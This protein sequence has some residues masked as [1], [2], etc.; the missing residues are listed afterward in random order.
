MRGSRTDRLAPGRLS[1]LKYAGRQ[2]APGSE[3]LILEKGMI[4]HQPAGRRSLGL[5]AAQPRLH[6]FAQQA[7]AL[8]QT[9]RE[10]RPA[11]GGRARIRYCDG[12]RAHW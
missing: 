8:V 12:W 3:N 7:R 11:L 6:F 10:A 9:L 4:V 2:R 5:G 1:F